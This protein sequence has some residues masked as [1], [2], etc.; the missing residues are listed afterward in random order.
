MYDENG[1]HK[2]SAITGI[3]TLKHLSSLIFLIFLHTK[4]NKKRNIK[5]QNIETSNTN[6]E[7]FYAM[8]ASFIKAQNIANLT[9]SLKLA[10]CS[11]KVTHETND[12]KKINKETPSRLYLF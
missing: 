1:W 12:K 3:F 8:A 4:I 9:K 6:R 10:N 11:E 2:I 7:K 5:T